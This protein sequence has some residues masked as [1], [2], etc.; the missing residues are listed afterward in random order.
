MRT[1][2]AGLQVESGTKIGL[3]I[4]SSYYFDLPMVGGGP[5]E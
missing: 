5:E 2:H 4:W 1:A 3:N